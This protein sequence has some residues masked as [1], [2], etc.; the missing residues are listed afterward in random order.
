MSVNNY[1]KYRG[2][3]AAVHTESPHL[4]HCQLA[5]RNLQG[6]EWCL[7]AKHKHDIDSPFWR[8]WCP[9]EPPCISVSFSN[10]RI[11][12]SPSSRRSSQPAECSTFIGKTTLKMPS[13][14]STHAHILSGMHL[15][16]AFSYSLLGVKGTLRQAERTASKPTQYSSPR[17]S[18]PRVFTHAHAH[19]QRV[20]YRM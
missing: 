3:V 14:A 18:S 12:G 2:E 4:A 17:V 20:E 1:Y 11:A 7:I 19:A 6:N 10:L 8:S 5:H 15:S 13:H 16:C 9:P